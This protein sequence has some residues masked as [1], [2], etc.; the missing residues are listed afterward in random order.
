MRTR[1]QGGAKSM[2]CPPQRILR[3][4]TDSSRRWR[5]SPCVKSMLS[6]KSKYAQYHSHI[7]KSWRCEGSM[8]SLRKHRATS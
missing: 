4:F 1:G 5:I 7:V 8:P 2:S 3:D 6:R